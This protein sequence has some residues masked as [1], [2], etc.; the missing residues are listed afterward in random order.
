MKT[1]SDQDISYR[2]R[3]TTVSD[4]GKRVWVYAKKPKGIY[5]NYRKILAFFLLAFFFIAP[6]IKVHGE[7]LLLFNIIERKFVIF[8]VVFWPQD[9]HLF[10]LTM[11]TLIVFIVLF[12]V[13]Y[14]RL[15]CGWLCPQTIFMEFI[16]RQIEWLIDG[17]PQ[18][19]RKLKNQPLNV[20]KIFKRVLKHGIYYLIAIIVAHTFLSYIIGLDQVKEFIKGGP[21]EY[22]EGYIGIFVFSFIFYFIFAWFRE[23]V[24]TI[25]CPYGRLQGVMLDNNSMVVAYDYIRGEPRGPLNK[26]TDNQGDCIACNACVAVCPTGIDIR[27]GTQLECINCT[28]CIDACDA[29][30]TR[31]KKPKGL[32][33]FASE[34]SIKEGKKHKL[35]A[36]AI[37]YSFVLAILISVVAFLFSARTEIETTVLRAPGTLFQETGDSY[38][39]LYSIEIVNKSRTEI[40]V[41]IKLLEGNGSIKMIGGEIV[42][43]KGE[44]TKSM[45]LILVK[46]ENLHSSKN[47]ILIGVYGGGERLIEEIPSTFVGPNILDK[48]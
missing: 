45:F 38:S 6:F 35:N 8:G 32:I 48:K 25:A 4:E 15:F 30:M 5:Y 33:R 29:V 28:A 7:Q 16:F 20:E 44:L 37:A 13:I 3:L 22:I 2:D 21:S 41:N 27:N 31:V 46:K 14:G 11:I 39:N 23:Q 10:V 9:F 12:T 17:N 40:P 34:F 1:K 26:N 47:K 24:C 19:Q 43:K 42:A 18:A 36:R